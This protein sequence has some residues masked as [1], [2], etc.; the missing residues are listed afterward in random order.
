MA[1]GDE[2]ADEMKAI[3]IRDVRVI[4]TAPAGIDLAVVKVETDEP[5]FYG[6]GC[7]T[8]TQRYEAV[9]TTVREYLKPLLVGKS[10][11][12]IE[13]TWHL[14]MNSG[15]WRNGPV[16]NNAISGVDEALWDIKGKRAGMPVYELWGGRCRPAA[17]LYTHAEGSTPDE[18]EEHVRALMAD[19]YRYIRCQLGIYGGHMGGAQ[20]QLITP[21]AALQGAYYDPGQYARVTLGLFECLRN[22]LGFDVE[23]IHDVHERLTPAEAI[24]F[25][26][27]M[28]PYRLFFLEDPLAPED[29]AWLNNLRIHTHTPIAMGELF[30]NPAEWKG[31]IQ[32]RLIDYLRVH[33]S[34]IGG[35]SPARKLAALCE[36]YGVRTAWHGPGDLS[37]VGA[38]AQ[39]HL[40]VACH[41][42]GI[43]EAVAFTEAER[44][45]FP[46]TPTIE[47]GFMYTNDKPGFGID[48]DERRAALYPCRRRGHEWL[49][50]RRPD[51]TLV[52]P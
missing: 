40:D 12:D 32:E 26:C 8:F 10:V 45:V 15:Y 7:A 37:P 11:D 9:A 30:N 6:L 47:N 49:Q 35:V 34:Q 23:L 14:M 20:Q 2:R 38:A 43:Q 19:G 51:G 1:H 42:F 46:G 52:R 33:V 4:L 24:R 16:L 17:T 50:A 39:L 31:L 36:A 18:V 44:E 27:D 5:E 3:T 48:V 29:S 21:K 25:A 41:N 13:D 22:R 28:E